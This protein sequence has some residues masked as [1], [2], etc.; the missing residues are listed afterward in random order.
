MGGS[1]K[2]EL[3]VYGPGSAIQYG[4]LSILLSIQMGDIRCASFAK[5]SF[6]GPD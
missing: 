5:I 1:E 3:S 2:I 4:F 6:S